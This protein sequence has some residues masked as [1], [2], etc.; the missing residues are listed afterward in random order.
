M[1]WG[2]GAGVGG[3]AHYSE[4]SIKARQEWRRERERDS[5][6]KR[7]EEGGTRKR[8]GQEARKQSKST[9]WKMHLAHKFRVNRSLCDRTTRVLHSLSA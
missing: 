9:E 4:F 6:R 2:M 7:R 1:C 8:R 3:G 5:D